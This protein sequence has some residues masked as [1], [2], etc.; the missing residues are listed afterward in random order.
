MGLKRHLPAGFAAAALILSAGILGCSSSSSGG[1]APAA[2][3]TGPVA[4]SVSDASTED[5]SVI[6][7][8][9]QSVALRPSGGGTPVTVL[10]SPSPAPVVNLVQL[11]SL[12]DLL[13]GAQVPAGS[14]DHAILTF[15]ANPGDVTLTAAANPSL[16]FTGITA[17]ATVQAGDIQILNAA[18]ST[19]NRTVTATVKL[20]KPL[21]VAGGQRVNLDLEFLLGHPA[22]LVPHFQTSGGATQW[23]VNFT[24][25][26][27]HHPVPAPAQ[28]VLRHI[29]G[30]VSQVASGAGS[31]TAVRCFPTL[32]VASPE[33]AV[34]TYQ[35]VQVSADGTNGTTFYDQDQG[36]HASLTDFSSIASSLPGRYVRAVTRFQPDGTL[37]A[38]RLWA[39]SSFNSVWFSPEGHVGKVTLGSA[40]TPYQFTVETGNGSPVPVVVNNETQFFFRTPDDAQADAT[41]LA[42]GTG[43]MDQHLLARGFKV[44]V[45]V[46][47]FQ[48]SPLV[49]E[50]VDIEAANYSGTISAASASG[51]TYTH[52]F[53]EGSDDYTV[54]LGYIPA[55][56]ANGAD[57]SGNPVTGFKWWNLTLA[58][59]ADTGS[60]AIGD[61]VNTV[62][63]SVD[64][65]GTAGVVSAWGIS[66]VIPSAAGGWNARWSVL[67]PL[68]MPRGQVTTAFAAS[69]TGGQFSMLVAGG[70]NRVPVQVTAATEVYQIDLVGGVYTLVP[71]DLTTTAGL[72][73]LA[74]NL[75]VN[76]PV[77]VYAVPQAG[78]SLLAYALCIT[79]TGA[80]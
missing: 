21:V 45:S 18:G 46:T 9:L 76:A 13:A 38:V 69:G 24:G 57:G 33:T 79:S 67:A 52:D 72:Q 48:S 22:F 61:F 53:A 70:V 56:V 27:V 62:G 51:F 43:F 71:V 77:I 7:V 55:S 2:V 60:G 66:T 1:S 44:H 5:W 26:L 78:G 14:Y 74:A 59:Q 4:L 3:A 20:V 12:S 41:P 17:G 11:D 49:A 23:T 16:G 54:A 36:T 40:S 39:G 19:G 73:A 30:Q 75:G 25:T 37:V 10:T 8:R 50:S 80:I 63:G 58:E 68:R 6:G 31:F 35:T 34:A 65:G 42:V 64:F 47:D 29:F 28:M 32:P 15:A